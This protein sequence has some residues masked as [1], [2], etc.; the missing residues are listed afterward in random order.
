MHYTAD[1]AI[2][3]LIGTTPGLAALAGGKGGTQLQSVGQAHCPPE[4]F[5]SGNCNRKRNV[6]ATQDAL[7]ETRPKKMV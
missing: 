5:P 7:S 4:S 1:G 6:G 2:E 3:D